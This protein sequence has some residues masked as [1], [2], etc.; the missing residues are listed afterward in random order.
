MEVFYLINCDTIGTIKIWF[1]H[2]QSQ[3]IFINNLTILDFTIKNL[4]IQLFPTTN[5]SI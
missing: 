4:Q 1:R 3:K 5:K 2:L